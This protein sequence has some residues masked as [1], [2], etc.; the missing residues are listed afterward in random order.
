MNMLRR[1]ADAAHLLSGLTTGYGG[2]GWFGRIESG[3]MVS[4]AEKNSAIGGFASAHEIGHNI[5]LG[6]GGGYCLKGA[7][8][9]GKT[10]H[11]IMGG[12]CKTWRYPI[13]Y[14]SKP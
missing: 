2:V 6:H 12:S 10:Y 9:N 7:D 8:S 3:E 1:G 13:N 5:G 14:Y 4:Y 11:T